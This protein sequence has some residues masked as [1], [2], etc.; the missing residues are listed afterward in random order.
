MKFSCILIVFAIIN[1]IGAIVN[2][3]DKNRAKR[4]EWRVPESTL[5]FFGLI[6]GATGSYITMKKIR[7]KTKHKGFM[8]G[9][10]MLMIIQLGI[11]TYLFFTFNKTGAL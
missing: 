7:H 2:I 6:G 11:M 1:I 9:M 10:P 8:T 4:D 3:V 5:W